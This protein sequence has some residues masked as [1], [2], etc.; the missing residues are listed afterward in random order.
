M[1]AIIIC[2]YSTALPVLG[3]GLEMDANRIKIIVDY[4]KPSSSP[5][6]WLVCRVA[7][8]L[9]DVYSA[10]SVLILKPKKGKNYFQWRERKVLLVLLVL[11]LFNFLFFESIKM[12]RSAQWPW[13]KSFKQNWK[14]G[15]DA[16]HDHPRRFRLFCAL[17][18]HRQTANKLCFCWFAYSLNVYYTVLGR[19]CTFDFIRGSLTSWQPSFYW[20][21]DLRS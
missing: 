12:P 11:V 20:L 5:T 15:N 9:R 17:F 13:L 21:L 19:G 18:S 7:L 2:P 10:A 6:S 4:C 3:R 16:F 8:L 1:V 14:Q